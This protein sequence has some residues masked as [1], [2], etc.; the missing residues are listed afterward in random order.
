MEYKLITFTAFTATTERIINDLAKQG[1]R[2][3]AMN[4]SYFLLERVLVN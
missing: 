1:W 3:V 2:V 4:N